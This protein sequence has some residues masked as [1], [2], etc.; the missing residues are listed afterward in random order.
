M[1]YEALIFIVC[2]LVIIVAGGIVVIK[3]HDQR[4]L[5]EI[6]TSSSNSKFNV[7]LKNEEFLRHYIKKEVPDSDVR[8]IL[9]PPHNS[10]SSTVWIY[11]DDHDSYSK[12]HKDMKWEEMLYEAKDGYFLIFEHGKLLSTFYNKECFYHPIYV[13]SKLKHMTEDQAASFLNANINYF[14][15]QEKKHNIQRP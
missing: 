6:I 7:I 2:A 8:K 10:D 13:I 11:I 4:M 12:Q 5:N 3:V 9:G 1:K 14:N 15:E